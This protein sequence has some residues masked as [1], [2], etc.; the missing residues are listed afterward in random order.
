MAA[1]LLN[2]GCGACSSLTHVGI[3]PAAPLS[4][5]RALTTGATRPPLSS[6]FQTTHLSPRGV[7]RSA[8]GYTA[9]DLV[10]GLEAQLLTLTYMCPEVGRSPVLSGPTPQS[11]ELPCAPQTRSAGLP[12]DVAEMRA[13]PLALGTTL[14]QHHTLPCWLPPPHTVVV[15]ICGRLTEGLKCHWIYGPCGT[16]LWGNDVLGVHTASVCILSHWPFSLAPQDRAHAG[17]EWAERRLA[18]EGRGCSCLPGG[19]TKGE[20]RQGRRAGRLSCRSLARLCPGHV[21][22]GQ[23]SC[24]RP[25]CSLW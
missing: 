23:H 25:P 4:S 11:T 16:S 15:L 13:L 7:K 14:T 8:H 19:C 6:T 1:H 24:P 17:S 18:Q 2:S 21:P 20:G 3:E 22:L 5:A 9:S 12:G 10:P